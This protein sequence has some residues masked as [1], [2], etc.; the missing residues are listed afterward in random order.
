MV[1]LSQGSGRL[2]ERRSLGQLEGG[3]RRGWG[4]GGAG[5]ASD[6]DRS[7]RGERSCR[8]GLRGR[9]ARLAGWNPRFDDVG[10]AAVVG[11]RGG[12]RRDSAMWRYRVQG[13]EDWEEDGV[14]R[15]GPGVRVDGV[16][17]GI[18]RPDERG[19]ALDEFLGR[20]VCLW[21]DASVGEKLDAI[22]GRWQGD[23]GGFTD[24]CESSRCHDMVVEWKVARS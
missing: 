21:F 12:G 16:G 13:Q 2:V 10:Q 1:W 19:A 18:T 6:V 3:R 4:G 5:G 7:A 15:R 22:G 20:S 14:Q 17:E 11:W 9:G 8:G 23:L 24:I